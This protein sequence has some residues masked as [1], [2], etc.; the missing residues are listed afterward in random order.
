VTVV[1]AVTAVYI[2]QLKGSTIEQMVIS[3]QNL[4]SMFNDD[5]HFAQQITSYMSSG[6]YYQQQPEVI[7]IMDE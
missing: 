6:N 3:G 4:A 2:Q 1:F 7:E 5:P